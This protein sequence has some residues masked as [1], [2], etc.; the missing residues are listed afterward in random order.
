M[1]KG[2][3]AVF[4]YILAAIVGAII[5]FFF[6]RFAF[7][8]TE[9]FESLN[10]VYVAS[11]LRDSFT[12][13][14][15]STHSSTTFPEGSWPDD[16]E[17]KMGSGDN[18]GRISVGNTN[19][20]PV[21]KIIFGPDVLNGK[22]FNVWTRIWKYP[23][24]IT[25]FFYINNKRTTYFLVYGSGSKELVEDLDSFATEA[26]PIDH[27]PRNFNVKA[28]SKDT[29]TESFVSD[30]AK[31]NDFV[32]FVFFDVLPNVAESENIGVVQISDYNCD[33]EYNCKGYVYFGSEGRFFY[34]KAMMYGAIF[35][36]SVENYDCNYD[37]AIESLDA[38]NDVYY[39][40][41]KLL[42]SK[43]SCTYSSLLNNLENVNMETFAENMISSNK[44]SE[45]DCENVF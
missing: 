31:T 36:G 38:V 34:G 21:D 32:K 6:V 23:Y 42:K 18:C 17:F 9:S 25:N 45:G 10:S 1:K 3:S 40:K 11:T 43:T 26:D 15:V 22:Q 27:A 14:S 30:S 39:G 12:S 28:I 13:L 8:S 37:R 33:S 20:I 2:I 24:K 35:A 5:L 19:Y 41:A 44:G 16:V 7:Y 29:I 4:Q